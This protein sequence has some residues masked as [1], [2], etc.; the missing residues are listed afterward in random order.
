M[1]LSWLNV[2]KGFTLIELLVVIA[3]IAILIGLLLPAVQ[4]VRQAAMITQC[5]NNLKQLG[6]AVH[7]YAS[8]NSQQLIPASQRNNPA[9]NM[10][11]FNLVCPYIEQDSLYQIA[12]NSPD[13]CSWDGTDPNTPSGTLRTQVVKNFICPLDS[14]NQNGYAANQVS[15]WA[16]TSYAANFQVF[17]NSPVGGPNG[18]NWMAP[19]NIGN[20]PNGTSNTVGLA[21]RYSA[22]GGGGNLWTWPGGDW[23]PNSWGVTFANSPWGGNWNMTMMIAPNPWNT[24]CDPTRP[25]TGHTTAGLVTMMDG[26]VRPVTGSVSQTTWQAVIVPNG[27]VPPGT[28]W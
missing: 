20:I 5:S 2:K 18:N 10:N 21:E 17:G 1:R 27:G 25:S 28:D 22:C 7:N 15:Q 11:F 23:G 12:I 4:K 19:F 26:S 8:T 3:I 16:G 6:L 24:A 13:A 14:S 9:I